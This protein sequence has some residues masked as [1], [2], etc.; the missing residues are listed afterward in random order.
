MR[1]DLRRMGVTNWRIHAHR[2]DDWKMVVKKAKVLHGLQSHGVV[3]IVVVVVVV[4][5]IP[6]SREIPTRSGILSLSCI[7]LISASTS[8][9]KRHKLQKTKKLYR[10]RK[11]RSY[12]HYKSVD[13]TKHYSMCLKNKHGNTLH[14]FFFIIT[15]CILQFI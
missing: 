9:F 14:A 7:N 1:E 3:V 11:Y 2:R 10:I 15:L 4:E 13:F 6:T 12:F 8:S 5:I